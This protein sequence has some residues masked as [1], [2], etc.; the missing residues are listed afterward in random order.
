MIYTV[1]FT[2]EAEEHLAALY[3]YIESEASPAIALRF[4]SAIVA[5]CEGFR[6]FP[7]RTVRRDDIRAGLHITNFK[8]RAVIAFIVEADRV[9]VIGVFYGGRDYETLLQSGDE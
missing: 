3:R 4:S 2:P 9:S 6:E 1:V 7:R 8:G 5:H